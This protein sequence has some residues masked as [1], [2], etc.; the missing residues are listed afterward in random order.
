MTGLLFRLGLRFTGDRFSL[1]EKSRHTVGVPF[2]RI[3]A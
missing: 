1:F 2:V 3:V